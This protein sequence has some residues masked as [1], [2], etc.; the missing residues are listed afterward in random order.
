ML[1]F[2]SPSIPMAHLLTLAAAIADVMCRPA[3][4]AFSDGPPLPTPLYGAGEH[5]HRVIGKSIIFFGQI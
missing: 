2:L 4:A 1:V 3:R 5:P